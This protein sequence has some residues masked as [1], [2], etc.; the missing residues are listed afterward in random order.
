M[1]TKENLKF[2][3][4]KLYII[5]LGLLIV[6]S[7]LLSTPLSFGQAGDISISTSLKKGT[8]QKSPELVFFYNIRYKDDK[9]KLHYI[10][11]EKV[12]ANDKTLINYGN[13]YRGVLIEG[14]NKIVVKYNH[15]GE[16]IYD[17]YYYTLD[18]K[19]PFVNVRGIYDHMLSDSRHISFSIFTGD[20]LSQ[21]EAL[22]TKVY[23][24]D[25][26][27]K[28]YNG[29]YKGILSS[30]YP[31]F[32]QQKEA[33]E[34]QHFTNNQVKIVTQDGIGNQGTY[35]YNIVYTPRKLDY[36]QLR[37]LI[38]KVPG[39]VPE[40]P[41]YD[42]M[43]E[44]YSDVG[45]ALDDSNI[46]LLGT[47]GGYVV[48][49]HDTPII[50][51]PADD[52][53]VNAHWSKEGHALTSVMVMAD[54]N[55]NKLPDDT[56]YY[57]DDLG[58]APGEVINH[59]ASY[60]FANKGSVMNKNGSLS[61]L[62]L[63]VPF[64]TPLGSPYLEVAKTIYKNRFSGAYYTLYG[65][66]RRLHDDLIQELALK[67]KGYDISNAKDINKKPVQLDHIDF[68]KVYTN[69][70][71]KMVDVGSVMPAVNYVRVTEDIPLM[72]NCHSDYLSYD[73]ASL[74]LGYGDVLS[75]TLDALVDLEYY[76]VPPKVNGDYV[77]EQPEVRD[78]NNLPY[79]IE[80]NQVVIF[81]PY[82]RS[83]L[84]AQSFVERI[85]EEVSSMTKLM[86]G[87]SG[88]QTLSWLD[89]MATRNKTNLLLSHDINLTSTIEGKL[90]LLKLQLDDEVD[91][92]ISS[93]FKRLNNSYE[94]LMHL[95]WQM[96]FLSDEAFKKIPLGH[97]S[98]LEYWLLEMLEYE[99]KTFTLE[100]R[101]GDRYTVTPFR[102][103]AY[104][105]SLEELERQLTPALEIHAPGNDDDVN[106]VTFHIDFY[107]D[108]RSMNKLYR[109]ITYNILLSQPWT[110]TNKLYH[111][112]GDQRI[113]IP[114]TISKEGYN[115]NF[116]SNLL[117]NFTISN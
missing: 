27:L 91:H 112:S 63:K 61:E 11:P 8:V 54:T 48:L 21:P 90:E 110:S 73:Y 53:V 34:D 2:K 23:L 67:T 107:K 13:T 98:D 84:S 40:K 109:P 72:L 75:M 51:G 9:G 46:T 105:M 38:E 65:N 55:K 5:L 82:D 99:T 14:E 70:F 115:I 102:N 81:Y 4:V 26:Q 7:S 43:S 29:L 100:P 39:L 28:E 12:F 108:Q 33:T 41:L 95:K 35:I 64:R 24:N 69:T 10:Q 18:S 87:D 113:E 76:R 36:S 6:F 93:N 3:S 88:I 59:K 116:E 111:I 117:G 49:G 114:V 103:I 62:V 52:F 80:D 50:N 96:D 58:N 16:T 97:R 74:N 60:A 17:V 79:K 92:R 45:V 89:L 15:Q 83:T 106:R 68:I 30:S 31:N 32:K 101:T 42:N 20:A 85:S 86:E 78:H 19:A 71:D 66:L 94:E 37:Y 56:W 1:T 77:F 22:T 47:F 104:N 44:R 57:I 25:V